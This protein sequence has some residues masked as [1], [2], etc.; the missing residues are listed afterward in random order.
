MGLKNIQEEFVK[1]SLDKEA[2]EKAF[3]PSSIDLNDFDH[4]K[5][6][7]KR[8][9]YSLIRKRLGVV[10]SI[11]RNTKTAIGNAFDDE[12]LK[13]AS[14]SEAPSGIDRHR[15]DS[16]Q[17]AEWLI[18]ETQDSKKSKP[19]K[20]LLSHELQPVHMWM[21]KK[22]LSI[23]FYS[24]SPHQIMSLSRDSIPITKARISP[25]AVM[26]WETNGGQ[27]CYQWRSYSL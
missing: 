26:W 7:V 24:R 6:S 22:K 8:H 25:T 17:F 15:K 27:S 20:V 5:L 13:F 3:D 4:L 21:S 9:A 16:I 19:L 10:K 2:R 14:V 18:K 12:F 11:L 1:L 23:Q